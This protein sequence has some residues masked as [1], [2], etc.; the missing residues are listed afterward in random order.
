MAVLPLREQR[1][2]V[3]E[4]PAHRHVAIRHAFERERLERLAG[5][6]GVG[7]R[8]VG[9]RRRPRAA[10]GRRAGIG[11]TGCER[12]ARIGDGGGR[13]RGGRPR[14]RAP[15]ARRLRPSSSRARRRPRRWPPT[16]RRSGTGAW[17]FLPGGRPE[18]TRSA[19]AR[20]SG[21][22]A[23]PPA[24]RGGATRRRRAGGSRSATPGA[25]GLSGTTSLSGCSTRGADGR[26]SAAN[27]AARSIS[28]RGRRR[29]DHDLHGHRL[30]GPLEQ[31]VGPGVRH[32]GRRRAR[33]AL[34]LEVRRHTVDRRR[35][36]ARARRA[37]GR[38][39]RGARPA[40]RRATPR[41]ARARR[42][43]AAA[44]RRP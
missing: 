44:A 25:G 31:P 39:S 27:A 12:G 30:P 28:A 2:D 40:P 10:R 8:L 15:A 20:A 5:L 22:P 14:R 35:A 41:P 6:Q 29:G 21:G 17:A 26:C 43:R 13:R 37:G 18:G 4:D 1:G 9:P 32:P 16:R 7:V 3:P 23:A 38:P 34:E 42:R 11:R 24:R 19:H 33:G 36:R